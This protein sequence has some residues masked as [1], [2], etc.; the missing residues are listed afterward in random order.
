MATHKPTPEELERI[1]ELARRWG[2]IIV[3]EQWGERGPGLDVPLDQM[4]Q[5][6]TAALRGLLA[7]TLEAATEQQARHLTGPPP[8]PD[9]GRP[10]PVITEDRTVTTGGGPFEHHEPKAHCPACRRDF[11]P[12]T[13]AAGTEQPRL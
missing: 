5:V 8:C 10:C 12:P 2:S 1:T 9:C 3:N 6:A 11:F 13:R 7:G 4:G